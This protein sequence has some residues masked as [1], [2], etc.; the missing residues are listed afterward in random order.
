MTNHQFL[1]G[2]CEEYNLPLRFNL[3]ES[4]G[5]YWI[6]Y[7]PGTAIKLLPRHLLN[8]THSYWLVGETRVPAPSILSH[9]HSSLSLLV[10]SCALPH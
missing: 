5:G 4:T 9:S 1:I 7:D 3:Y 6:K 2:L 8:S 10:L